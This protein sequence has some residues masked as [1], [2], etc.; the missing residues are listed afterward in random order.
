MIEGKGT[1][2]VPADNGDFTQ[3]IEALANNPELRIEL[4]LKARNYAE[5]NLEYIAIM[6]NFETELKTT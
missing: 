4:V 6:R 5:N 2:V 3:A 1:V